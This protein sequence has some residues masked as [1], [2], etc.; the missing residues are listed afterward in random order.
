MHAWVS[1]TKLDL[2]IY[3]FGNHEWNHLTTEA[4]LLVVKQFTN[5]EMNMGCQMMKRESK[6]PFLFLQWYK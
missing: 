6:A 5:R 1:D 4:I 3:L 2:L